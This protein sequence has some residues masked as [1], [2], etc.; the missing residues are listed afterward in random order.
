MQE[1]KIRIHEA[2]TS[3][4]YGEDIT[5]LFD[6]PI[7]PRYETDED[8]EYALMDKLG[9]VEDEYGDGYVCE[10]I[11]ATFEYHG[12][13]DVAIPDSIVQRIQNNAVKQGSWVF[14]E[15]Q[16]Y[17]EKSYFCSLCVDGE[18]ENGTDNYCPNCGAKMR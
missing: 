17:N 2:T 18:S 14:N 11:E 5:Q 6:D 4:C 12:Y 13:F 3:S 7:S 9:Y 10:D 15:H 1:A 8:A 16:A